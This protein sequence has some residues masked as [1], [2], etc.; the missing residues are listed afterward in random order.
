MKDPGEGP[1]RPGDQVTGVTVAR[2]GDLPRASLRELL[3]AEERAILMSTLLATGW[4]VS[5]AA[6]V[7]GLTRVGLHRKLHNLGIR[8]P[9]I[10]D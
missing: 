2:D 3:L 5:Q 6:R 1:A 7:L 9:R 4:N 10:G 8:R